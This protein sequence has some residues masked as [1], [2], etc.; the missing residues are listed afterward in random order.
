MLF[1]LIILN[2]FCFFTL[3]LFPLAFYHLFHCFPLSSLFTF[4]SNHS[5]F[6]IVI[7]S[8]FYPFLIFCFTICLSFHFPSLSFFHEIISFNF[9]FSFTLFL[10]FLFYISS[11]YSFFSASNLF[12]AFKSFHFL[13]LSFLYFCHVSLVIKY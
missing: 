2:D 13:L 1:I 11:N 4:C 9:S 5:L 12:L 3:F 6:C 7:Q 8:S 10:V